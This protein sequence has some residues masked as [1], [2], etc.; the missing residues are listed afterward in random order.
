[1]GCYPLHSLT[2]STGFGDNVKIGMAIQERFQTETNNL[3]VIYQ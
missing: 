1:M 2:R 3:M